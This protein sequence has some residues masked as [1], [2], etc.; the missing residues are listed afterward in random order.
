MRAG[1]VP[2]ELEARMESAIDD[3]P[4]D[5]SVHAPLADAARICLR[6]A[7]A[8]GDDRAAA[9]HLLAAD[10]LLTYACEAAAEHGAAALAELVEV[11]A[12][13]RLA[14]LTEG[15]GTR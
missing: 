11:F 12:S 1:P 8:A 7:L 3:A 4:D 2:P 10:A 13:E 9:L 5:D 14:H 6:D 15:Q